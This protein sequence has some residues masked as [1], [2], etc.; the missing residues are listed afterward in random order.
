MCCDGFAL[1]LAQ[2]DYEE[3]HRDHG[4]ETVVP[5]SQA[6]SRS[7]MAGRQPARLLGAWAAGF[8]ACIIWAERPIATAA[9]VVEKTAGQVVASGDC[10][11]CRTSANKHIEAG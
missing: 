8:A 7:R 10:P 1:L 5:V 11:N 6:S 4:I 9:P 3:R 2:A